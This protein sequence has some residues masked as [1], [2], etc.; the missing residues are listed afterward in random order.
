MS[1]AVVEMDLSPTD[2]DEE[3]AVAA[4]EAQSFG[5]LTEGARCSP[6]SMFEDVYK[7]MPRHLREQRQES[8]F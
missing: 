7:V 2:P 8:G 1:A 5:T 4:R 3:I 6:A